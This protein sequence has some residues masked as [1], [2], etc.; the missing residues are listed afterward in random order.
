MLF[1]NVV[2]IWQ[3]SVKG[4]LLYKWTKRMKT[5]NPRDSPVEFT[6]IF[7]TESQEG[8]STTVQLTCMQCPVKN[9][10]TVVI[11]AT[12]GMT[13]NLSPQSWKPYVGT[14]LVFK[15]VRRDSSEINHC[16]FLLSLLAKAGLN[17]PVF[18]N[19]VV[20]CQ[21][22]G[23]RLEC[24]CAHFWKLYVQLYTKPLESSMDM[25]D[26]EPPKSSF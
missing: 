12:S 21:T 3:Y 1:H 10:S 8:A 26:R 20:L 16:L 23:E 4:Y 18:E 17:V 11:C 2:F 19:I 7:I 24:S 9:C 13:K 5:H 25:Y 6:E 14:K 22:K 15:P